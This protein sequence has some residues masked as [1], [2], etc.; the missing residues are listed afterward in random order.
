MKCSSSLLFGEAVPK[1]GLIPSYM[2][3]DNIGN[4]RGTA[5]MREEHHKRI[6][7]K[8][9]IGYLLKADNQ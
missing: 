9:G 6:S 4:N 8:C 7:R 5:S 1:A 3:A 2:R